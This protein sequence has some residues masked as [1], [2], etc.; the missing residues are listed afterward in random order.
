MTKL[1]IVLLLTAILNACNA[2][3]GLDNVVNGAQPMTT[4]F[5]PNGPVFVQPMGN[6]TYMVF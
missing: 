4:V 2:G 1:M 6:N 5:T 3:A